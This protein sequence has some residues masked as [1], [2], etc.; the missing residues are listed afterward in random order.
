[1]ELYDRAQVGARE[2]GFIHEEAL[3]SEKAAEFYFSRGRDKVA[4]D[5]LSEAYYGYVR[6][7]ATVKIRDLETRYPQIFSR[8]Q[9]SQKAGLLDKPILSNSSKSGSSSES[10]DFGTVMKASLALLAK[11]FWATCWVS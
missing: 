6:W 3:A 7:G 1:M 8:M 11:S 10:L 2:Q 9:P 5:Y 4:R